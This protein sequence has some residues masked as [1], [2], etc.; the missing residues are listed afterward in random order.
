MK[1]EDRL[2]KRSSFWAQDN[3]LRFGDEDGGEAQSPDNAQRM[4]AFRE[5]EDVFRNRP[6]GSKRPNEP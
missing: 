6:S 5:P 4:V 2:G 3:R 1:K